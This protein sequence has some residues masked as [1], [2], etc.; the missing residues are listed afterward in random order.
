MII[1]RPGKENKVADALT[2]TCAHFNIN[3]LK[4]IHNNLC[5]PGIIRMNHWVRSKNLP[6]SMND[7]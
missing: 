1:Y 7:I 6:Y 2:R 3:N 5:H 4:T